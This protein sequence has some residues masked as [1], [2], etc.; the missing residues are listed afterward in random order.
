MVGA[1][2]ILK[3]RKQRCWTVSFT[4]LQSKDQLTEVFRGGGSTVCTKL[5]VKPRPQL[6]LVQQVLVKGHH[7]L[8]K[9]SQESST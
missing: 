7:G 5:P 9:T 3:E 8:I 2:A 6:S 1:C 4:W